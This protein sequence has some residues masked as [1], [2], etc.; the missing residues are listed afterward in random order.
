[1]RMLRIDSLKGGL[2]K[3]VK[4]RSSPIHGGKRISVKIYRKRVARPYRQSSL[5]KPVF[6]RKIGINVMGKQPDLWYNNIIG[7]AVE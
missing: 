2:I 5:E 1:M 4:K 7:V 6:I 3:I